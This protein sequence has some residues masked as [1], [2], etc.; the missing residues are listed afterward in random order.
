MAYKDNI[1][2]ASDFTFKDGYITCDGLY[3]MTH[4]A[5]CVPKEVL[6]NMKE[7][8]QIKLRPG[9]EFVFNPPTD[10][11]RFFKAMYKPYLKYLENLLMEKNIEDIKSS[12]DEDTYI[13]LDTRIYLNKKVIKKIEEEGCIDVS[14]ILPERINVN[15][16][17]LM[18]YYTIDEIAEFGKDVPSEFEEYIADEDIFFDTE[19]YLSDVIKK[20]VINR[21]AHLEDDEIELFLNAPKYKGDKVVCHLV[22]VEN[23][24]KTTNVHQKIISVYVEDF[25]VT[26]NLLVD[27]SGEEFELDGRISFSEKDIEQI[28]RIIKK[29]PEG[30]EKDAFVERLDKIKNGSSKIQIVDFDNAEQYNNI[31]FRKILEEDSLRI[32]SFTDWNNHDSDGE[33]YWWSSPSVHTYLSVKKNKNMF[34]GARVIMMFSC[35]DKKATYFFYTNEENYIPL[36]FAVWAYFGSSI[37]NKRQNFNS[38]IF[39]Y[40]GMTYFIK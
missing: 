15:D 9:S 40:F 21:F 39:K 30:K 7:I 20:A 38:S 22:E 26:F 31:H 3:M 2:K 32:F 33:Y 29:I 34:F 17:S 23:E 35:D 13:N 36:V 37:S 24:Y 10:I 6:E 14:R 11:N 18:G 28:D 4:R 25:D 8:F 12:L 16:D 19:E 27:L 5:C 1:Y